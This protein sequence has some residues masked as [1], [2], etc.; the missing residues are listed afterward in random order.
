MT[1]LVT[2]GF[3]GGNGDAW[4]APWTTVSGTMTIQTNRGQQA[5]PAGAYTSAEARANLTLPAGRVTATLRY[6]TVPGPS[7][8]INV[9]WNPNTGNGY[10]LI[11]PTDYNGM[12]LVKVTSYVESALCEEF[13]SAYPAATDIKV[14]VEFTGRIIRAKWWLAAGSEPAIWHLAAVDATY[15]TG[16]VALVTVNGEAGGTQLAQW[17]NVLVSDVAVGLPAAR[18]TYHYDAFQAPDEDYGTWTTFPPA[19]ANA[20]AVRAA[21]IADTA[22][23]RLPAGGESAVANS[24][25]TLGPQA[26]AEAVA[27][28]LSYL[29]PEY[30]PGVWSSWT[31]GQKDEMA[32]RLGYRLRLV[33]STL[34]VTVAA[35]GDVAVV[36]AIAND[37]FAAVH[38]PSRPLQVVFVNGGAT[39]VRTLAFD[40]RTI[41]PG[42]TATITE[43]VAA[44]TA[45]SWV[46]YLALPDPDA[47]L[48]DLPAYAIQLANASMWDSVAGRN[49]LG[50]TLTVT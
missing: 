8:R 17:D 21:A 10:R 1:D 23:L 13:I 25:D 2:T 16:D 46:M 11:L 24:P 4:P 35:G 26:L 5:T 44:P 32:R 3:T 15:T 47:A 34:P 50:H 9:R 27:L 43:T 30:H 33:S 38:G 31:Q 36:A 40:I 49:A 22:A 29:N 45:G 48:D 28:R 14:A 18:I 12:Q 37:G 19:G 7:G 41:E 20:A 39:V 42:A 6:P